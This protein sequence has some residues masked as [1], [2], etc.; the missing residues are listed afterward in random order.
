MS[1]AFATFVADA[2]GGERFNLL[3]VGCS[4]GLDARWRAFGASLRALAIDASVA[5][6]ERLRKAETNPDIE[7]VAAFAAGGTTKKIDPTRSQAS[8][9]ILAIRERLSFWRTLQLRESRL[10]TAEIEDKLRHNAWELTQL[11]DATKPT[12]VPDLLAS[13]GWTDVDYLKI[14]IDGS[15]WEVLQSFAG[16]L[17]TLGVL[18]VQLEVNFVGTEAPTEHAFHNTDRFMRGQGFELFRLDVRNYSSRALPARYV[19]PTPA[20]TVSGRPWQGEA[21]YAR[22]AVMSP[23]ALPAGKLAK[24]AAIFSLW[25][26]P[27]LAAELLVAE[28]R[29]LAKLFDVDRGLDL[30]AA[31]VQP[32]RSAK[33]SYRDYMKAFEADAPWFYRREGDIGLGE[34]LAAAWRA[35]WN[36]RN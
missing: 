18:G 26:V 29:A 25:G 36:P 15:D 6:C 27:D 20:E 35:Y 11:A 24:L 34:R 4:G 2:L 10:A 32:Q 13:K 17:V 5:E 23:G 1:N 31:Q 21:Y 7:Y 28:R 16:R 12:V 14:D 8:D 9:L 3:D 33:L 19:W 30:L 22:D